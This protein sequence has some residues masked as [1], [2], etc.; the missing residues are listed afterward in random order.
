MSKQQKIILLAAAIVVAG[1]GIY[2]IVKHYRKPQP[3]DLAAETKPT[4]V[5]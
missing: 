5:V 4:I 2:F 3:E 1:V